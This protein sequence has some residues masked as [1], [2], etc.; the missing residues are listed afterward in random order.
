MAEEDKKTRPNDRDVEI[1]RIVEG[2]KTTRFITAS[3]VIVSL[4]LIIA[5]SYVTIV[6][7]PWLVFILALIAPTGLLGVLIR[8]HLAY[9]KKMH[10]RTERLEIRLDPNRTSS[11]SISRLTENTDADM[12]PNNLDREQQ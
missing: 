8:V 9:V 4:V 7:P 3:V 2:H 5:V 10:R 11:R 12:P 1:A 6:K